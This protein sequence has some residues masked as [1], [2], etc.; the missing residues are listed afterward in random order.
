MPR[1]VYKNK[2]GKRLPGTTTIAGAKWNISGLMYWANRG[3]LEGKSLDEMYETSTEPGT[4]VHQMIEDFLKGDKNINYSDKHKENTIEAA[5]TAFIN[6]LEWYRQND[7][8]PIHIE[9]SLVSEDLQCG[10]TPDLIAKIQGKRCLI[11]WKS[12]KPLKYTSTL[13]QLAAYDI[14]HTE[15]YNKKIEGFYIVIIPRNEETPSFTVQYRE[16]MPAAAY[17]Q[18][19]LLRKAYENEKELNKLL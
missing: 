6:W 11:D 17:E 9:P 15:K 2:A 8:E 16:S 3:G 13:L 5:E 19:K 12:G 18:F 7:I 4:L 10:G 14:M 1:I